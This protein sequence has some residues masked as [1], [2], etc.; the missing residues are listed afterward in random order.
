MWDKAETFMRDNFCNPS[1]VKGYYYGLFSFVKA[2]LLHDSNGDGVAE[3]IEFLQSS[4]AGVVPIDWYAAEA[5]KGAPCDGVARTLANAQGSGG[6]WWGHNASGEQYPFETAMAIIMLNRTIFESGVP[7]AVAQAIPNP[8][9][10]GQTIILDGSASFHQD[11][12]KFVDS[13]QWDLDNDGTYDLSGPLATVSFAALGDYTIKLLV[14]DNG[15]PEKAA[16]TI[17]IVRVTTPP[18]APTADAG[19]P[20]IFCPQAKPWYLDARGSVNPDEGACEAGGNPPDTIQ[21]YAWDLD[22]DAQFDD[23]FGPVVDVSAFF[24]AL[25]PG[26]Y[27][28]QLRVTDTTATSFP[29]SGYPD[30]TDT[31]SAQVFVREGTSP[32]CACID[33]LTARAKDRKIQLV[34]THTG[35]ASYNVYRSTT[36]GGPYLFIANTTSTYSTYLDTGLVNGTRYYYVVREAALNGD[37]LCQSNEASA[38]PSARAR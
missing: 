31:D 13:W 25:G 3:P 12:A 32:D 28:V 26:N 29:S 23:A 37:E 18:V 27:L 20:Y 35:A 4:T 1:A 6:W 14:T 34:W 7:V 22:G 38:I 8:A 19:G 2:M 16:A 15:T 17:V 9:V 30:L 5:S 10:V 21:Q 36:S 24:T 11:A 33:N